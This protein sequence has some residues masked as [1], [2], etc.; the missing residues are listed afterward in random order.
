MKI[1]SAEI[2]EKDSLGTVIQSTRYYITSEF[3]ESSGVNREL[4]RLSAKLDLPIVFQ[5]EPEEMSYLVNGQFGDA[6][7]WEA[8]CQ[9][10]SKSYGFDTREQLTRYLDRNGNVFFDLIDWSNFLQRH[11]FLIG[12]RLHG[13]ILA[14]NS[15][16][17]ACLV[18]HDSRTSE[19]AR[20]A[21]IPFVDAQKVSEIESIHD[22]QKIRESIEIDAYM[23]KRH[24]NAFSY[25]GFLAAVGL[26]INYEGMLI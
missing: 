7:E 10:L 17:P 25:V 15:G 12:T 5:S 18:T 8:K 11:S 26:P 1:P 24:Q 2:Q 19:M 4:F 21:G 13:V 6:G 20:Y 9:A 3:C 22:L 23:T 16:V 14:L